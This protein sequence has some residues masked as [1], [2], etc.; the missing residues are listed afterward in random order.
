MRTPVGGTRAGRRPTAALAAQN[1]YDHTVALCWG[2]SRLRKKR[3]RKQARAQG[4]RERA[5]AR[6]AQ[7]ASDAMEEEAVEEGEDGEEDAHEQATASAAG[8]TAEL[9]PELQ[10]LEDLFYIDGLWSE[11]AASPGVRC[12]I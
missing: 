11:C 2:A 1:G 5:V 9:P 4:R 6:R 7:T 3:E 10:L 12:R 8:A